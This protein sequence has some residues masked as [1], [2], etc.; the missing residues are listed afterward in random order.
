VISQSKES[1]FLH[2]PLLENIVSCPYA[3]AKFHSELV[4]T[5]FSELEN[6]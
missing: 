1:V 6:G 5:G 2:W 4:Y 3:N